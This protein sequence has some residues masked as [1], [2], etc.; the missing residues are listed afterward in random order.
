MGHWRCLW[1][2]R[3]SR[4]KCD[5]GSRQRRDI[6]GQG[7]AWVK[8]LPKRFCRRTLADLV[9]A[10]DLAEMQVDVVLANDI[11]APIAI[12]EFERIGVDKV[13]D[14][15]KVV[16]VPDHFA[17]NKDIKAAEQCLQ[18]RKFA[19]AQGVKNYFEVGRMG[20]EHVLLPEQGLVLAGRRGGGRRLAHLHLWRRGRVCHRYGID[21][22]CRGDGHGQHL[23]EG[24]ADHPRQLLWAA[25]SR[26]SGART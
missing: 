12:R 17:P 16:L 5:T 1:R 20:I 4:Y 6:G 9:S 25:C 22:H 18:L 2:D 13:F 15:D 11:T 7:S 3:G 19:R 23:D 14:P 26:G 10:G 21:G 8:R 24:A